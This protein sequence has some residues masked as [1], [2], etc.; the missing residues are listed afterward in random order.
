MHPFRRLAPLALALL[1]AGCAHTS[2]TKHVPIESRP[3]PPQPTTGGAT[4]TKP[5][6]ATAPHATPS[7]TAS[8]HHR[9]ANDTLAVHAAMAR[10]AGRTLL[11]DQGS[12]MDAVNSLL[13]DVRLA[14]AQGDATHAESLA[15]QARSLASSLG[16]P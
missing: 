11:P 4:T 1:L 9:V 10:C 16:C 12:T 7:S 15:R 8:L 5:K 3:T 2:R 6:P 13:A 14:L